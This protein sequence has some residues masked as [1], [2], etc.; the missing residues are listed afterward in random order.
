MALHGVIFV[1]LIPFF[2]ETMW[3]RAHPKELIA[4]TKSPSDQKGA[5]ANHEGQGDQENG[6][7]KTVQH[8]M[9]AQLSVT[10]TAERDP[11]LGK[12]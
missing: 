5:A 8:D 3:H 9:M 12:G 2:P 10:A 6:A 7:V 4:Q 11:Y 1:L